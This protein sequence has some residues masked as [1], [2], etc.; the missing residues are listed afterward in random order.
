[1]FHV[2]I[3]IIPLG[4]GTSISHYIAKAVEIIEEAGYKPI[5]GPAET[6]FEVPSLEELGKILRKIHDTLHAMG[7]QRIITTVMIDDRRD[8]YQ[9]LKAKVEKIRF[10]KKTIPKQPVGVI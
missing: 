2:S 4:V 5:I 8:K 9:P 6:S 1:M 7:V 10:L 3:T